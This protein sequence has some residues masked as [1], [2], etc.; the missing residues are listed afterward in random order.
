MCVWGFPT[1]IEEPLFQLAITIGIF[2]TSV[3]TFVIA[4]IFTAMLCDMKF[5][6]F[7]FFTLAHSCTW[8]RLREFTLKRCM[9]CGRVTLIGRNNHTLT[10]LRFNPHL[11]SVILSI[12]FTWQ[13]FFRQSKRLRA[14]WFTLSMWQR[15]LVKI[16]EWKAQKLEMKIRREEV[17][18]NLESLCDRDDWELRL[19]T[20]W[21]TRSTVTRLCNNQ[22]YDSF[23]ILTL[24]WRFQFSYDIDC[25][26]V[27]VR[28]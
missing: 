16:Y 10:H 1:N 26:G 2:V 17:W 6:F 7:I 21:T 15:L 24:V 4:Q 25:K 27:V 20:C 22:S 13:G 12:F 18:E 23:V 9:L 8:Q 11:H 3:L 5:G 28:A 14:I 19:C